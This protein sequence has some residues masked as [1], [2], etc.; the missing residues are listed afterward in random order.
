MPDNRAGRATPSTNRAGTRCS[1]ASS[2]PTTNNVSL[3]NSTDLITKLAATTGLVKNT[4]KAKL[5][6][7]QRS[8]IALENNYDITT[9]TNLLISTSFKAKIPEHVT[10][11]AFLMVSEFHNS[12]AEDMAT[13]VNGKTTHCLR[14]GYQAV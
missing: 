10:N 13:A 4:S 2:T 11:V 7:E 3:P 12:F 1:N 14:T 9:L 5:F 8:L 6:L